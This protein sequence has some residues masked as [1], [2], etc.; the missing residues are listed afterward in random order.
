MPVYN[1]EA[2][3]EQVIAEWTATLSELFSP[4]QWTFIAIN[5]GSKD[6]SGP[7]LD[8]LT[9]RFP[10]LRPVHKPN[11]GHGSAVLRGYQEALASQAQWVFQ[12]DSDN[13]FVPTDFPKLWHLRHEADF[14]LGYRAIRH[15]SPVRLSITR[16]LRL[17]ILLL[18]GVSIP[19]ANIPYRLIRGAYLAA[20][21]PRIPSDTF[22]PNIFLSVLAKKQGQKLFSIPVTH[23]PRLTGQSVIIRWKLVKVC[24]NCTKEVWQFRRS[25]S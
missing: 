20:L 24:W 5:D 3:L 17:M 12:I 21:L 8:R 9:A 13:Q 22:I 25:L 10:S 4:D 15:D 16:I 14:I 7:L 11:G 2:C 19:D 1:E 18:F 23:K 6:G